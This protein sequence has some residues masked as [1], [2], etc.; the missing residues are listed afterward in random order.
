MRSG[1]SGVRRRCTRT[2][3]LKAVEAQSEKRPIEPQH[4]EPERPSRHAPRAQ[5]NTLICEEAQRQ[6]R[7]AE[8]Q[9]SFYRN[10]VQWISLADAIFVVASIIVVIQFVRGHAPK[11]SVNRVVFVGPVAAGLF[12][13]GAVAFLMKNRNQAQKVVDRLTAKMDTRCKGIRAARSRGVDAK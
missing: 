6:V 11:G 10:L 5:Q 7:S 2:A 13:S 9:L 8:G 3:A 1:L 4:D 12:A